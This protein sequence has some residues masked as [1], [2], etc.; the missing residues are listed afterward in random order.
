MKC[1]LIGGSRHGQTVSVA[2]PPLDYIRVAGAMT[3]FDCHPIETYRLTYWIDGNTFLRTEHPVYIHGS[4][5]EQQA[6]P[7]VDGWLKTGTITPLLT[8]SKRP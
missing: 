7:Y 2:D 1:P 4:V 6:Q 3:D 8:S 5:S